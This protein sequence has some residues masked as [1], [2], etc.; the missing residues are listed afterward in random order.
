ML[1]VAVNVLSA[2]LVRMIFFN[3]RPSRF[4]SVFHRNLVDPRKL[5]PDYFLRFPPLIPLFL[6]LKK[7]LV[8]VPEVFFSRS[9]SFLLVLKT[10][11][12]RKCTRISVCVCVCERGR[13]PCSL[14]LLS[15]F[16]H[17]RRSLT[18]CTQ[19]RERFA[20]PGES[21]AKL[22]RFTVSSETTLPS[23]LT[24]FLSL[25]QQQHTHTHRQNNNAATPRAPEGK[26]RKRNTLKSRSQ[27]SSLMCNFCFIP[28]VEGREL[29]VLKRH[30]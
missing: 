19:H 3:P 24:Y 27:A 15:L 13:R 28:F 10:A 17:P 21:T 5:F 9:F 30:L 12:R 2:W 25:L 20:L 6:C 8:K 23:L 11:R 18:N 26:E 14:F 29:V 22:K 16:F 7:F 4:F 1:L